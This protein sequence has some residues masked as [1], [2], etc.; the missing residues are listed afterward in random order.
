MEVLLEEV[1]FLSQ[2]EKSISGARNKNSNSNGYM[3]NPAKE[4]C[5]PYARV[6]GSVGSPIAQVFSQVQGCQEAT[7]STRCGELPINIVEL[8]GVGNADDRLDKGLGRQM[9]A[10]VYANCCKY[11]AIW[12]VGTVLSCA[13]S[14]GGWLGLYH[15]L[16]FA[17][18]LLESCLC[19]RSRIFADFASVGHLQN[20]G[21]VV[22]FRAC[23]AWHTFVFS[24]PIVCKLGLTLLWGLSEMYRTVK[25]TD[26]A[27]A[28]SGQ[29]EVYENGSS[30]ETSED[31]I[32]DIQNPRKSE[33][34]IQQGRP[35]LHSDKDYHA[36]WGNS[37]SN[38][39]AWLHGP[40]DCGGS[41]VSLE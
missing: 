30:G 2:V 14:D 3:V 25:T 15:C 34:S 37:S 7:S 8:S 38:K 19:K 20:M 29:S 18:V 17:W 35:N 33:Q 21:F 22:L 40:R 5:K 12:V 32:F 9:A 16:V 26:R 23:A 4:V 39:E 41:S 27:T 10:T 13:E 28:S 31:M 36:L 6:A 24:G 11:A 1:A